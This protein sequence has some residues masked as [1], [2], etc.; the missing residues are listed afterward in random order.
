M[1]ELRFPLT[2]AAAGI[3][4]AHHLTESP[5]YNTA[6][7]LH[8]QAPI[9]STL[10]LQA[11]DATIESAVGLHI[12]CSEEE[13][14]LFQTI[15]SSVQFHSQQISCSTGEAFQHMQEDVG[16]LLHLTKDNFVRAILFSVSAEEHFLYL[17]I[18]HLVSD[19][20]SFRLL[21][22]KKFPSAIRLCFIMN[23]LQNSLV[24]MFRWSSRKC[25]TELPI[26][27]RRTLPTGYPKC[28]EPKSFRSAKKE[29]SYGT[30]YFVPLFPFCRYM[31]EIR[32]IQ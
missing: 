27:Q 14:S 26:R 29:W 32:N 1:A 25:S 28:K 20:Y 18:H 2:E 3:W 13:G 12:Q 6:E 22:R 19:A 16:T 15:P 17:R 8:I 24:T 21:F 5:L 31:G 4:Y 30:D 9:D 23:H 10:L 7:Y 11:V